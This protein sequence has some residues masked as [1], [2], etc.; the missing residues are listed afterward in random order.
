MHDDPVCS[1]GLD[2]HVVSR[3]QAGRLEALDRKGDLVLAG[4]AWHGFTLA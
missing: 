2:H 3:P 4:D 1:L